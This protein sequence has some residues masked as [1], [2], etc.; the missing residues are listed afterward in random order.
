MGTVVWYADRERVM[1]EKEDNDMFS[2][3]IY[4]IYTAG[5]Y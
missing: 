2:R 1:K 3:R 4:L 5:G